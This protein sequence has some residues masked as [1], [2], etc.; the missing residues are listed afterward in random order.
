[1]EEFI[2]TDIVRDYECDIQGIVNNANYQHYL[3]HARHQYLHSKN[4]SFSDLHNR[5]IDF[6]VAKVDI[7]YKFPLRPDDE[8]E[9]TVRL[10]KQYIKY[11]F[12]QDI[13]RK[14]D[15]KMCV[16]AKITCVAL[17]GGQLVLKVP[18]LDNLI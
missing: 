8:Y 16:R 2:Y 15:R 5:G 18:E 13:Y 12:F 6:V 7:S 9:C 3:E 10:E 14:S 17:V 1:M 11:V 4:I